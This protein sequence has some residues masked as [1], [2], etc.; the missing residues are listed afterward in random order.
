MERVLRTMNPPTAPGDEMDEWEAM[1]KLPA[2]FPPEHCSNLC[3][4]EKEFPYTHIASKPVRTARMLLSDEE[5][6]EVLSTSLEEHVD[7]APNVGGT[8]KWTT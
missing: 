6:V 2:Q 4:L 3:D 1:R 7:I 8:T 5:R